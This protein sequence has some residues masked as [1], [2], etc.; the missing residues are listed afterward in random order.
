MESICFDRKVTAPIKSKM[1]D[2]PCA[3]TGESEK[4]FVRRKNN[5]LPTSWSVE[6]LQTYL[7]SFFM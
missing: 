6:K 1:K 5:K 3:D 2:F 4:I 7:Y